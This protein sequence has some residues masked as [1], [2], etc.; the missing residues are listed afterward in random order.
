MNKDL[1]HSGGFSMHFLHFLKFKYFSFF[2]VLVFKRGV[3][4]L[5]SM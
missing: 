2:L 5:D 3:V 4:V 1:L